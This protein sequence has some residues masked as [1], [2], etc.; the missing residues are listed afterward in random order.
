MEKAKRRDGRMSTNQALIDAAKRAELVPVGEMY[1]APWN[2]RTITEE[3]LGELRVSM[4]ADPAHLWARPLI[5]RE[6]GMIIAGN[7]RWLAAQLDPP[8]ESL[9]ALELA[10]LSDHDAQVIALRDNQ[11]YAVWDDKALAPML[12]EMFAAGIDLTLTGFSKTSVTDLLDRFMA[13]SAEPAVDPNA[14]GAPPKKPRSKLGEVYEL[15]RHRLVCGDSTDP[16]TYE[17]L[18]GDET[19]DCLFTDPPY[20]VAYQ[21][22]LS[23]HEA[24]ARNR[25]SDGLEVTNDNLGFAGTQKLITDALSPIPLKPGGVLYVCCPPGDL[26]AAFIQGLAD[27]GLRARHQ[28]V[29]VKD[30]FVMGRCDYHYRH[31]VILYGWK[32][33][34][35]HYFVDDHTQDSV[36]EIPRPGVS[37]EH[38][39]MKPVELVVRALSNSTLRDDIILDP[40]G[41][42]GT[43][44]IAAEMTG[45]RARIVELDE[46][47]CDV[48]RSRWEKFSASQ[49]MPNVPEEEV[50]S[51]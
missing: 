51:A 28:I 48:I 9:P 16:A 36:W 37:K 7:H 3:R 27:A 49:A 20:G 39:T 42:S 47:Y 1:P 12:N 41:G 5:R 8:Y 25:R 44:L 26:Q 32:E 13:A 24:A 17:L 11:G 19:V 4:D 10:G 31:E 43:T 38:P 46:G 33:G 50:A 23:L 40:F 2:P 14:V 21:E 6:D 30:R 34:A 45:R 22:A 18:L 15:G 35:G 29:W